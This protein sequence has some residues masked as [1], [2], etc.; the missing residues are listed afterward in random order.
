MEANMSYRPIA[1]KVAMSLCVLGAVVGDARQPTN[2]QESAIRA[3]CPEDSQS[4]AQGSNPAAL[5]HYLACRRMPPRCPPPAKRQ[6]AKLPVPAAHPSGR[7]QFPGRNSCGV[8]IKG[9]VM[10]MTTIDDG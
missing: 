4:T 9:V 3:A 5:R 8:N 1:L 10:M 7:W 6:S 2:A